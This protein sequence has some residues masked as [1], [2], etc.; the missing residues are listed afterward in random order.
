MTRNTTTRLG[1]E[2]LADRTLPSVSLTG[3]VLTVGGTSG[4]D[5]IR[6]TVENETRVRVTISSTGENRAFNVAR[7]ESLDVRCRAGDDRV[8]LAHA[9]SVPALVLGQA[10]ND[11]IFGGGGNDDLRGDDGR[12]SVHGRGGDDS[13]SGG[14]GA[15]DVAG[16]VGDDS[17]SGGDGSDHCSGGNGDDSVSGGSGND[18]VRGDED[19]DSVSG[20]DGNDSCDGGGGD[21]DVRGGAGDDDMNG[22]DGNDVCRGDDGDDTSV[23]GFDSEDELVADFP[24]SGGR[25]KFETGVDN[26]ETERE[27]EVEVEDLAASTLYA[28]FV[29]GVSVGT[30]TTDAEG[31][32]EL[33]FEVDFDGDDDG[34]I[35]FP[36]GFPEINVGDT[37]LV[38]EGDASGAVVRE[39]T[40][41]L[42]DSSDD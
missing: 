38:R 27:F 39:G 9:L 28:V 17:L 26:D 29:D 23:D 20:D 25:A 37:V 6:V 35:E 14:R 24:A 18:D 40:F 16:D 12:D 41:A 4:N 8:L 13:V 30:F 21:D 15:D 34:H 7:V 2:H 31:R 5:V 42:D 22:G 33:K 1:C 11:T 19:N 3:G 32:G 10:G 36:V